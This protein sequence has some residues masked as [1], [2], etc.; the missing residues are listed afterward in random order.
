MVYNHKYISLN[1]LYYHLKIFIIPLSI[2]LILIKYFNISSV[3]YK[4]ISSDNNEESNFI[5]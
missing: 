5:E 4:K 2:L 3:K 1:I